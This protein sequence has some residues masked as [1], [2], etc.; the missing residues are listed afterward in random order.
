VVDGLNECK[1][2]MGI[3]YP[4]TEFENINIRGKKIENKSSI[5]SAV[6]CRVMA[7]HVTCNAE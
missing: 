2:L 7:T 4:R 5:Y 1:I 6:L 3:S